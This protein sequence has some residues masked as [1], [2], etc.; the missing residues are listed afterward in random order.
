M[1]AQTHVITTQATATTYTANFA[2]APPAPRPSWSRPQGGSFT[3]GDGAAL[4]NHAGTC[5]SR[6]RGS[7]EQVIDGRPLVSGPATIETC[8][9][10]TSYDSVLYVRTGSLGGAAHRGRVR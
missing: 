1:G 3:V 6:G 2:A 7:A 8:G 9:G 4:S 10:A 5:A